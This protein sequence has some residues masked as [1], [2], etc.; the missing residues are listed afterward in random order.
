MHNPHIQEALIE[1]GIRELK[2]NPAA[3]YA[4]Q[5]TVPRPRRWRLRS[6]LFPPAPIVKAVMAPPRWMAEPRGHAERYAVPAL[7]LRRRCEVR[8]GQRQPQV[9]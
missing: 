6:A 9:T 8:R 7:A 1:S 2:S 5:V 3:A 4:R